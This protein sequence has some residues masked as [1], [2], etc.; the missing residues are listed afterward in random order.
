MLTEPSSGNDVWGEV[1]LWEVFTGAWPATGETLYVPINDH[2][3]W[4]ADSAKP[5][6]PGLHALNIAN[7]TVKWSAIGKDRCE[8]GTKWVCAPGLSAAITLIPGVVF[9]GSLDGML[10]AY[11]TADGRT[12][13]EFNTDQAFDSV[14]G[15][16]GVRRHHRLS[17]TGCGW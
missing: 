13:W 15:V 2:D 6:F 5:A 4:P 3:A 8:K 10:H 14:N 17:G 1:A 16:T 11:S 9:G 7:G 12:L